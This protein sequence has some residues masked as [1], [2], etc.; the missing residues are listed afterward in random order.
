MS[1]DPTHQPDRTPH[2]EVHE[3]IEAALAELL[4][5]ADL[6]SLLAELAS[7]SIPEHSE[8]NNDA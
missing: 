4:E 1:I 2:E 8:D 7:R 5:P 3:E 6:Q